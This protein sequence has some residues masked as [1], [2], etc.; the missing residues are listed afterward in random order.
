M[1]VIIHPRRAGT[2]V[3]T[4]EAQSWSHTSLIGAHGEC[5][6]AITTN[7]EIL[8]AL[9]SSRQVVGVWPF[10]C[11]RRYWCG[12]S[13]FGFEAGKRSPRGEGTFTFAT[14]QDDEF[15]RMF[16]RYI[17]KAKQVSL[18]GNRH[19][20]VG[21]AGGTGGMRGG[22]VENR[23]KLPLPESPAHKSPAGFSD[24]DRIPSG[25]E[26]AQI[27]PQ[28]VLVGRPSSTSPLQRSGS[29]HHTDVSGPNPMYGLKRAQTARPKRIQ[30][31]VEQT[32]AAITAQGTEEG[33]AVGGA[34]TPPPPVLPRVREPPTTLAEEDMYS[35]TQHMM[36]APFHK[37]ATVHNIVEESTYHT[38]VHEKCKRR[39][40][41]GG[42]GGGEGIYSIAY[43]SG[44]EGRQVMIPE[45]GNEYG[46]LGSRDAVDFHPSRNGLPSSGSPQPPA[47]GKKEEERKKERRDEG[48][49]EERKASVSTAPK[50]LMSPGFE[51]SMTENLMYGSRAEVLAGGKGQTLERQVI[52]GGE[53]EEEGT[54]KEGEG[55]QLVQ[56]RPRL[57]SL[58]GV[59]GGAANGG[60]S[61]EVNG[62]SDGE[63]G[64]E[65]GG[66]QRDAKGYSKV[67]K[68]KKRRTEDVGED[69]PPPLPPRLY[70][71]PEDDIGLLSHGTPPLTPVLVPAAVSAAPPLPVS[72]V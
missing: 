20:P 17:N 10:N 51:D 40:S 28:D 59:G 33:G 18:H 11:L 61:E 1:L 27:P 47:E 15:Y 65:G 72:D 49:K 71:E 7:S 24:E 4:V 48:E 38:L 62:K 23:P 60:S 70:E 26:Y 52:E 35:H 42:G 34:N 66:I 6:L 39:A 14:S 31:W 36:P 9:A 2:F 8:C 29:L 50:D 55:E 53:V 13:V 21:L 32:E 43:P 69:P 68:S 25:E 3:C 44:G 37:H 67:D 57:L 30:Q 56:E 22:D 19:R 45:A 46:T 64:E 16:K 41:E 63:R 54:R 12:E 5:L 58:E